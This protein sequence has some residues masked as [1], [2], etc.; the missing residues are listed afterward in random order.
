M[1]T[2]RPPG[3]A[4]VCRMVVDVENL[5]LAIGSSPWAYLVMAGILIVDGFF[6]F[7]PGE[8]GVVTLSTLVAAN[9]GSLLWLVLAVAVAATMVGDA[10][11]F[12]IGRRVGLDR[13]GWMRGAR[14]AP[15]FARASEG[16]NR[17]PALYLIGAK[18]LPFVRVAVTM[19]AG[20]SGLE[21]RRYLPRSF[22]ASAI[23]TL[24]HVGIGAA[25]GFW[26]AVNPIVAALVA[27]VVVFA[28]GFGFDAI[29]R[30]RR[31]LAR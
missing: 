25:A 23:Y 11:S 16:L 18:F 8:T 22:V 12:L 9:G 1:F 21:I 26:F 27:I 2:P 14:M 7:V 17:R 28:L 3:T 29:A 24:Y 30:L 10:I 31:R 20:A 6:P 4:T 5:I 15:I 13:W 19:T